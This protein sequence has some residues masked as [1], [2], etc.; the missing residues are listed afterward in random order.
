MDLVVLGGLRDLRHAAEIRRDDALRAGPRGAAGRCRALCCRRRPRIMIKVRSRGAPVSTKRFSRA[1]CSA[2][3][4]QLWTKPVVVTTSL[5][6]DQRDGL[7]RRNDLV[8][9]HEA[10]DPPWG[11][12]RRPGAKPAVSETVTGRVRPV[13]FRLIVLLQR[14]NIYGIARRRCRSGD[15]I[16]KVDGCAAEKLFAGRSEKLRRLEP[17]PALRRPRPGTLISARLLPRAQLSCSDWVETDFDASA[18]PKG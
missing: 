1:A 16:A 11:P 13:R 10:R 4:M 2:S 9:L 14:I 7:V 6:A 12:D 8:L 15:S 18:A 17:L 3:G 5:F